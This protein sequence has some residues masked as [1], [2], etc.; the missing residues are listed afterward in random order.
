MGISITLILGQ[1]FFSLSSLLYV[2]EVEGME[3]F[4]MMGRGEAS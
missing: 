4:P 3:V 2:E 1:R